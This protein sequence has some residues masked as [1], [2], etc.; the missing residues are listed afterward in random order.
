MLVEFGTK[1]DEVIDLDLNSDIVVR[2]V[3]FGIGQSFGDDFADLAVLEVF[4]GASG[5]GQIG[6]GAAR[7]SLGLGCS[8]SSCNWLGLELLNISSEDSAVRATSRD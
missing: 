8:S 5:R 2:D 6:H 3:L 1:S 4:V 7:G